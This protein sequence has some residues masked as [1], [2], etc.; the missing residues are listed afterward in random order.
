M[1]WSY[2]GDRAVTYLFGVAWIMPY[3]LLYVLAFFSA[4]I[5]DTSIVWL[6]SGVT[7]A[8]MT[9][10][11]LIGLFLIRREVKALTMTYARKIDRS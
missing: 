2:Y 11:N 5:I 9:I 7:L 10:P 8:L 6:I 4:T 3:R 1:A